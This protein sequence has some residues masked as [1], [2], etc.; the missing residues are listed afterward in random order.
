M[1]AITDII[2]S[3]HLTLTDDDDSNDWHATCSCGAD[4]GHCADSAIGQRIH[5]EHVAH[6]IDSD[7]REYTPG[8]RREADKSMTA[9]SM[10]CSIDHVTVPAEDVRLADGTALIV[11]GTLNP[12]LLPSGINGNAGPDID[13]PAELERCTLF[14]GETTFDVHLKRRARTEVDE[15]LSFTEVSLGSHRL[16]GRESLADDSVHPDDL[17]VRT[18][19]NVL[20][21]RERGHDDSSTGGDPAATGPT[22]SVEVTGR[23]GADSGPGGP[24]DDLLAIDDAAH[25]LLTA[26]DTFGPSASLTHEIDALR[27]THDKYWGRS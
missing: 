20:A 24:V 11:D 26:W 4:L 13:S 23:R 1:T 3:H 5:A 19:K 8:Q 15:P 9:M 21:E 14:V 7:D 10:G 18:F 2:L 16:S 6:L 12:A 22:D 17:R 25:N 27:A